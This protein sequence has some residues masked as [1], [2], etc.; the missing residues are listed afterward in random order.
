MP[1]RREEGNLGHILSLGSEGKGVPE[2]ICIILAFIRH[3]RSVLDV[4]PSAV[5]EHP[6]PT[7]HPLLLL[8][9]HGRGNRVIG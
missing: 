5:P 9:F 1:R 7:R 3:S 2:H 8:A 6:M 4:V